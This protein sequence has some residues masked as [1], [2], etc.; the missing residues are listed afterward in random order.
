RCV[1]Q[2]KELVL[3]VPGVEPVRNVALRRQ[4]GQLQHAH[5]DTEV[6]KRRSGLAD[7]RES[8]LVIV[9]TRDDFLGTSSPDV[10]SV[11]VVPAPRA[12]WGRRRG[13]AECPKAIRVLRA[14]DEEHAPLLRELIKPVGDAPN[15]LEIPDP[16]ASTI[17]TTETKI[18]RFEANLLK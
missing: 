8:R 4:S 13:D 5:R 3:P 17:W 6:H 9:A 10:L 18:F 15:A 12:T 16:A 1:G 2:R 11:L 7:I 14:F